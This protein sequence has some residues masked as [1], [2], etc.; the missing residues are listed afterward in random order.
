MIAIDVVLLPSEQM[1][2]RA[3]EINQELLRDHERLI[4]LDKKKC[5][6]HISLCMGCIEESEIP[7]IKN[8]L[9][10]IASEFSPFHLHTTDLVAENTPAGKKVSVL[11]IKNQEDLQRL[12]ET[13]MKK[14]WKY[15]S[16]DVE[17]SMLFNPPEVNKETLYWIRNYANNYEDPSLF[18]PHITVG[19]GKTG[20]FQTPIS[21]SAS[22]IALCQLGNYCTCRKVIL[23]SEL[24][25]TTHL[26]T[27]KR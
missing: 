7:E 16:Y 19:L 25:L 23:T 10:E 9:D 24:G 17:M 1:M 22:E 20:H 21:F 15:L 18:D 27:R 13:V 5:L 14:L 2:N 26:P 6:P 8:Q 4:V 11:Q 12:H 3:I